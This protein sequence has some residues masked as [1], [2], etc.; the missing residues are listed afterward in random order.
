MDVPSKNLEI[1]AVTETIPG[2][3]HC[4]GLSFLIYF[5]ICR[6]LRRMHITLIMKTKQRNEV[7]RK[8]TF[9]RI[10]CHGVLSLE[11]WNGEVEK[12]SELGSWLVLAK[13][14]QG[15][16]LELLSRP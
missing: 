15:E 1:S 4:R 8:P 11:K 5:C 16:H 12:I 14:P 6:F 13:G 3:W 10:W 2:W 9:R 7:K